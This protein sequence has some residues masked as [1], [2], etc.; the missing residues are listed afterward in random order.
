MQ[1]EST[2][3]LRCGI[4]YARLNGLFSDQGEIE[5]PGG[6]TI[7]RISLR[8]DADL[9]YADAEVRGLYTG[10][11]TLECKPGYDPVAKKFTVSDIDIKLTDDNMF[12]R[13]AGKMI[14]NMLGDKLDAKIEELINSKFQQ[15]LDE[16]LGQLRTVE[17]PKGGTLQ[18][19]TQSWQLSDLSTN[20]DGLSVVAALTGAA[21]LEY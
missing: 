5:T 1:Q 11:A 8:G 20:T 7:T 14:N 16:I 9:L 21:I 17:L 3:Y 18:F 19:D 10:R 13:F 6:I 15:V 4:S 12:A 2:I